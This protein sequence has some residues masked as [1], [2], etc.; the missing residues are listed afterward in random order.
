MIDVNVEKGCFTDCPLRKAADTALEMIDENLGGR[1]DEETRELRTGELVL[2]TEVLN[3]AHSDCA[4]PENEGV[5]CARRVFVHDVM[6][7]I[8]NQSS[9][10]VNVPLIGGNDKGK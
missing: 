2:L 5:Y 1:F 8:L 3:K 4:G 10:K 6:S 7:L 9:T